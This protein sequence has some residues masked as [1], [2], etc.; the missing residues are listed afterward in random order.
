MWH[1]AWTGAAAA[2][3]V[4]E[5]PAALARRQGLLDGAMV[6]VRALPDTP[7]AASVSA[8][9]DSTDD[10]EQLELNADFVEEQL[11]NQARP[12]RLPHNMRGQARP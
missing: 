12:A 10:W 7:V 4:L 3:Q 6:S 11:L 8:E 2:G 1:V 9:P 5:V